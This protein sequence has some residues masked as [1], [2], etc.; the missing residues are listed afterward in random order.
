MPILDLTQFCIRP[1]ELPDLDVCLALDPTYSTEFVWQMDT[2]SD[3]GEIGV[4]FRSVRLPRMMRVS[5]PRSAR[6]LAW[7]WYGCE[8]FL[9]VELEEKVIAYAALAV[10]KDQGS[11]YI[12]DIVVEQRYRQQGVGTAL[13]QAVVAWSK[14]RGMRQLIAELQTKNHPAICFYQKMGFCFCGFNDRYYANQDIAIF[15]VRQL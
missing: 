8:G 11:V 2:Y 3:N 9:V 13:L 1:A 10:R 7:N 4:A 5:Y 15:F 14:E 6:Q 12:T